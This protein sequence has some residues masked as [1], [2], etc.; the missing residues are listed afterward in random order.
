MSNIELKGL[1]GLKNLDHLLAEIKSEEIFQENILNL[2]LN[3]LTPGKYQPRTEFD[4]DAIQELAQSI[5]S[6]GIILPLIVRPIDNDRFE[7]IAGERRWRAAQIVGLTSVPAVIR[8]ISDDTALALSLIENIQRENLNA[9]DEATALFRLKNDFSLT[10]E[11]IA[12]RVGR[13]RSA[14]SNLIRLLVLHD[15]VKALLRIGK[16]EMGHGRAL[17]SL[18]SDQQNEIAEYIVKKNLSVRATEKLV[19]R[20]KLSL[21]KNHALNS[22]RED[23]ITLWENQLKQKF[24]HPVKIFFNNKGIAKII[25]E[26][27]HEKEIEALISQNL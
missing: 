26:Q 27:I 13:S 22:Q 21:E 7:I 20:K 4:K 23:K 14:V 17:L 24:G 5:Q 11:E 16:L 15:N 6:Q 12:E 9:M 10:H 19:S 25:I 3:K 18:S 2:S 1:S 8:N